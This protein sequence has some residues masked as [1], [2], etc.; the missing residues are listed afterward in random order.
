MAGDLLLGAVDAVLLEIVDE[1][2]VAPAAASA[3]VG[4]PGRLPVLAEALDKDALDVLWPD[5]AGAV[6]EELPVLALGGE[7]LGKVLVVGESGGTH[8][9][10]GEQRGDGR[11]I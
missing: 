7:G 8:G 3:R 10:D 1:E 9:G 2:L 6:L 4:G 11:V 5:L